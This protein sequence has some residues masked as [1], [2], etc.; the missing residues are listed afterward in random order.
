M[1]FQGE[2]TTLTWIKVLLEYGLLGCGAFMVFFYTCALH[3]LRSHW[4]AVA[5]TF[6]FFVL[7]SGFASTQQAFMT[8]ILTAYICLK[9]QVEQQAAPAAVRPGPTPAPA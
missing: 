9:P 5:S 2:A 7:D 4:L 6:H 8:L 1:N 3:T